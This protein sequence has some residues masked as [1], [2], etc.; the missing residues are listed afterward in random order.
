M[1][2]AK[3][4]IDFMANIKN[5]TDSNTVEVNLNMSL[6]TYLINMQNKIIY[7]YD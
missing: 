6:I 2:S 3:K 7:S 5:Y 1:I 4:Y